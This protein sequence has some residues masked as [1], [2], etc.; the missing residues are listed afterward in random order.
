MK[1]YSK[2]HYDKKK[3]EI[4]EIKHEI[5]LKDEELEIL[6]LPSLNN[7]EQKKDEIIENYDNSINLSR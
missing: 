2:R 4:S 5:T 6:K 7:D 3:I 1:L